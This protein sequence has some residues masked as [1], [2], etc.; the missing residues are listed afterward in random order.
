MIR[1]HPLFERMQARLRKSRFIVDLGCGANPVAG[2]TA[3]VDLHVAP[4]ERSY[5]HGATIDVEALARRGIRFVNARID[6]PLPFKD[7]EFDFAYSHHVFEHLIDPVTAC[8]EM[9]RIAKAGAVIT[10]S[11]FAELA[12]GRVY[13]RWLVTERAGKLIFLKKRGDEDRPFGEHPEFGPDLGWF[14]GPDTNPFDILL[15]DGGWYRTPESAQ[16][17]RLGDRLRELWQSHSPVLET[18]FLWEGSFECLVLDETT[19]AASS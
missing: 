16:F 7:K 15:N 3:A 11:P 2:A 18:I 12:F 8:K 9:V 10:P 1:P 5:G 13:H 17:L 19:P 14:A 4:A 6:G